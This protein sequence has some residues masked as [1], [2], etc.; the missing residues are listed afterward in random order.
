MNP[1]QTLHMLKHL[2]YFHND[3]QLSASL[4]CSKMFSDKFCA[5]ISLVQTKGV[6]CFSL[7]FPSKP[8]NKHTLC[9]L[10]QCYNKAEQ[11]A[12]NE[13]HFLSWRLHG[14]ADTWP[15]QLISLT[16]LWSAADL[17]IL[18]GSLTYLGPASSHMTQGRYRWGNRGSSSLLHV[19]SPI[20]QQASP[21]MF[22]CRQKRDKN[23][24]KPRHASAFQATA[25]IMLANVLLAKTSHPVE[26]ELMNTGMG[27]QCNPPI[28]H[29]H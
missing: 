28:T 27:L 7:L 14:S 5:Q 10:A 26:P 24:S 9:P 4:T 17:L 16:C 8:D 13:G 1:L 18:L 25:N 29:A 11:Q 23:K 15:H 20:F 12:N 22:S 6:C 19:P 21:G 2:F 3:F